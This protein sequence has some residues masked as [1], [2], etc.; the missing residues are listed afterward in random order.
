MLGLIGKR[1]FSAI[2]SVIGVLVVTFLLTRALP[3]DPAAFFAGPAATQEAIEQVR[4]SLGLDKSL[5]QQFVVYLTDLAHGDLG[6]SVAT[7][8]S[9]LTEITTRLPASLE[10]TLIA[11][12]VSVVIAVPLGVMAATKPGSLVD[13]ACR[14]VTTAGVSLPAFFTGLLLI[15]VQIGR[16]HV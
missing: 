9:V 7:G 14:I 3:G 13:H 5:L 8:Q 15:Y 12:L 16:A 6:N 10:L 1:I 4:H 2:P 11:L